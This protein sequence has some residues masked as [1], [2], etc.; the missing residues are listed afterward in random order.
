MVAKDMAQAIW[1]RWDLPEA[2]KDKQEQNVVVRKELSPFKVGLVV[3]AAHFPGSVMA[4]AN[5]RQEHYHRL[6]H[7][8]V[9]FRGTCWKNVLVIRSLLFVGCAKKRVHCGAVS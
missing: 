8:I 1:G 4:Y 5:R 6:Q 2:P 7:Y 9:Y 3:A